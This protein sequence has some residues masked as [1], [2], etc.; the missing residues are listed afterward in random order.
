M[1]IKAEIERLKALIVYHNERY[2]NLDAPE[3]SDY[4]YDQLYARLKELEAA[5]PQ[6]ASADSPTRKVGGTASSSFAPYKHLAPM[7]S[8][9]NWQRRRT[10]GAAALF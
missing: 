1:E 9:P 3:I 6:Y 2:Y 10:M 7:L 5:Y 4:E 8:L